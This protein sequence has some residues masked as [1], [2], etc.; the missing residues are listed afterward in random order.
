MLPVRII[1]IDDEQPSIEALLWEIEGLDDA[2]LNVV[3][4][5]NSAAMGLEAIRQ[6]RPDLV[7][8][9]IEM[10]HTN[11]LEMLK[12]LERIQFDVVFTTA[13]D[14][15]AVEAFRFN[16]LDYLLKPVERQALATAIEKHRARREGGH[17]TAKLEQL[18]NQFRANDPAFQKIAL[19]SL[20]GLF[21][22]KVQEITRCESD[23]NYTYIHL[24]SGQKHLVSRTLREVE[25]MI[26]NPQFIRIHK[27]HLVNM[28][29]VQRYIRGKDGYLILE[30]GTS[31]PVSRNKKEDFFSQF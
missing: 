27:S 23:S 1:I 6:L 31:V 7:L 12:Q 17:L 18:F 20:E 22:V 10:P 21:F 5:C 11:G 9:D 28:N 19:P 8:L 2:Q 24:N 29:F 26:G 16:A 14:Q 30:D 13:Y 4:T 3:A 15:Y 25:E